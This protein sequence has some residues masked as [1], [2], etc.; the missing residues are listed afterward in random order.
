MINLTLVDPN[1]KTII[2]FSG[3]AKSGK[4]TAT[5]LVKSLGFAEKMFAE[6][7]KR[8]CAKVFDIDFDY[9]ELQ[10]LKENP[11]PKQC[12]LTFENLHNILFEFGHGSNPM[13]FYDQFND[14]VDRDFKTPREIAQ[15]VGTQILRKVSYNTGV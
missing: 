10:S 7:L 9:F 3:R 4:S 15:I 13:E 5:N 12:I 1:K 8:V 6:K 11:V 2:A 14:F